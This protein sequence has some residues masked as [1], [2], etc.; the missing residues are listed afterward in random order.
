[1]SDAFNI[2]IIIKLNEITSID[3]LLQISQYLRYF[4]SVSQIFFEVQISNSSLIHKIIAFKTRFFTR[5]PLRFVSLSLRF[6][7]HNSSKK[8]RN[9][10]DKFIDEAP[11]RA[12][13]VAC[14]SRNAGTKPRS[15][16][17]GTSG[18][19]EQH[20]RV[21]DRA[22]LG[23]T[24]CANVSCPPLASANPHVVHQFF[25]MLCISTRMFRALLLSYP[26]HSYSEKRCNE[27]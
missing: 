20:Y 26:V 11:F 7:R 13:T 6:D 21:A 12:D 22:R 8:K 23:F 17:F 3:V 14:S 2:Y 9:F 1:M 19:R 18:V 24:L 15:Y 16:G 5:F 25:I 27:A 10:A 4:S